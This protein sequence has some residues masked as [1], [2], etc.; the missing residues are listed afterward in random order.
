[1]ERIL[2]LAAF[3]LLALILQSALVTLTPLRDWL[4]QIS[5]V[6][7]VFLATVEIDLIAGTAL[8]LALGYLHDVLSGI[9]AGVHAL[10][11]E[12]LFLGARGVQRRFFLRGI[13]FEVAAAFSAV[14][15]AAVAQVLLRV[16]WQGV[17]FGDPGGL[18][19]D[20][21]VRAIGTAAIAP[22]VFWLGTRAT[23]G[24]RSSLVARRPLGPG[25]EGKSS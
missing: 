7:I 12:V 24:R 10:A 15:A 25:T 2:R 9:P 23:A 6:A 16:L 20:T 5:L 14:W 8:A 21:L 3:C 17:R 18:A 22:P 19:V 11:F 13:L 1:M 4:P